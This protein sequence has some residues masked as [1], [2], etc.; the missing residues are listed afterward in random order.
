MEIIHHNK[1]WYKIAYLTTGS[2]IIR[3]DEAM[4]IDK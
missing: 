1:R 2:V 3:E 4:T